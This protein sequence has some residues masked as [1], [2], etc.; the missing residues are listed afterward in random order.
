MAV[1][2]LAE[3]QP[4]FLLDPA[5][6]ADPPRKAS[7][8]K[9]ATRSARTVSLEDL[10]PVDLVVAGSVAVTED[11]VRLGKGGGF[12]DLEFAV[13]AEAGLVGPT[14]LVT[15]TV[16]ELQV[17][18]T[19]SLPSAAHDIVVDLVVTPDRVVRTGRRGPRTAR[20]RWDEL[21]EEK[22]AA[23]PLLR[24]LRP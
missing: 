5:R 19:G 17:L 22:V 16:H 4:F 2:R 24:K 18:P 23:I 20:I 13:A 11:G 8:I 6:L 7:S 14:T 3:E 9:G 21:T 1:P 10:E 15:T 12:I